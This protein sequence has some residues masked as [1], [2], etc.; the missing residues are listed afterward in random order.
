LAASGGGR[1][2]EIN[3]DDTISITQAVKD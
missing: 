3:R 2:L 1:T